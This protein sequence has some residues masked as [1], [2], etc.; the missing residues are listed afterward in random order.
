MKCKII[1]VV[2]SELVN[3]S[4]R[5]DLFVRNLS[6][7]DSLM[8]TVRKMEGKSSKMDEHKWCNKSQTAPQ[9]EFQ[10]AS[11]V[12]VAKRQQHSSK[13]RTVVNPNHKLTKLQYAYSESCS[14]SNSRH[15]FADLAKTCIIACQMIFGRSRTAIL[16]NGKQKSVLYA[17]LIESTDLAA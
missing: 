3:L 11:R 15:V 9:H 2:K 16:T 1:S 10:S 4:K 13:S 17:D 6:C 8:E 5:V 7:V 14:T 12:S